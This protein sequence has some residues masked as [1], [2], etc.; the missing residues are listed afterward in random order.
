MT[1]TEPKGFWF[2]VIFTAV[3]MTG[4]QTPVGVSRVDPETV[5][6]QLTRNV[7]STGTTSPYS[8]N[9]LRVTDLTDAYFDDPRSALNTLH[10]FL[11]AEEQRKAPLA[12]ALAE[13]SFLYARKTNQPSYYL[14]AALYAYAYLFPEDSLR[15]PDPLD[16]RGRIAADL[17]NRSLTS[18]FISKDRFV[19]NLESGTYTLPFGTLQVELP[20]NH[21]RWENRQL[22]N[23]IP[24]AELEVR[25]LQ[26][27]YR[28]AGIGV[29]LAADQIP[30]GQEEGLQISKGKMPVTAFMRLPHLLEQLKKGAIQGDWELYNAYDQ[31]TV[32]IQGRVVPLE[33][34]FTSSLAA[35]LAEAPVWARELKGFFMGDSLAGGSG[36]LIAL[37][38]YR[39]GRIPVVF[40]H[41]TASGS[42]RW[43]D[44]TNDLIVDPSIR[45]QFQF[46]FFSYDTGN[47]IL[48]SAALFR[49][50]LQKTVDQLQRKYQDPALQAMVIIGHSQGGLLTKLTAVDSGNTFWDEISHQPLEG[51][52]LSDQTRDLLQ[53][54]LF[55]E[56]LPFVNRLVFIATPQHGSYVAGSWGA[57]QLAK[58]VKLPGRVMSGITDLMTLKLDTLKLDLQGMNLGSVSAMEP[59]SPLMK[60][61]PVTPLAPGVSGHSIIAVEGDGPVEEGNDGV[62]AYQSAHLEG[63][64]SEFVVRSGHSC[65]SNTH[66]IQEVRRILLLHAR[67]L[68]E[69]HRVCP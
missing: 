2:F 37:E 48:Y 54:S 16:P 63:M 23:F 15:L 40:V 18:G 43:A 46:W 47:P 69:S 17:Y 35:S 8:D 9:V 36:E 4:C 24:V 6:H 20:D 19:M 21:L 32:T 49:E 55:I 3:M 10:H 51:M 34:E 62:V 56:S 68:C 7:L 60:I 26:N 13:L 31:K 52:K 28:Q 22:T 29:P 1:G 42:G 39:P 11:L 53:R 50:I 41:G 33:I 61:L 5:R 12:F 67:E 45:N 38:P 30:L 14:A 66:T 64:A 25:G 57:H 65:Q 27:R 58:F 59:G 44:M